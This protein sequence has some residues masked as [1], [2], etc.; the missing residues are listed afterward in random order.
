MKFDVRYVANLGRLGLSAEE[1]KLFGGQLSDILAY[2]EKIAELDLEGVE[3]TAHA[4]PMHNVM[5]KDEV[6]ACLPRE[7]ALS[8]APDSAMGGFKVPAI[9]ER[10]G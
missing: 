4:V 2:V 8:N 3:P 5:R 9:I 6:G 7:K 10:E 1:E